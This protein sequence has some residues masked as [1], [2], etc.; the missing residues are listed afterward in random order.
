METKIETK[1]IE[2]KDV[3]KQTGQKKNGN[4]WHKTSILATDG[5]Y[6][7]TFN[8]LPPEALEVGKTLDITVK[9]SMFPDNYDIVKLLDISKTVSVPKQQQSQSNT[10]S[11]ETPSVSKPKTNINL[12]NSDNH[13]EELDN[14]DL[15]ARDLLDRSIQ[16]VHEALPEFEDTPQSVDLVSQLVQVMHSKIISDRIAKQEDRKLNIYGR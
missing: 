15:Y 7:V 14:A 4:E 2:V 5:K 8:N 12:L 1:K 6:Y 10:K 9:A 3:V 16:I 11:K 13:K